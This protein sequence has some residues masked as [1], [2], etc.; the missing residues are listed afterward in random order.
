MTWQ[1]N[2]REFLQQASA[3][4]MLGLT[5]P[6]LSR[7]FEFSGAANEQINLGLIGCG[8]RGKDLLGSFE[9]I[10]DVKLIACCDPDES[11]MDQVAQS[12]PDVA[13][14]VDYRKLLEQKEIDAVVIASTNHWHAAQAIHSLQA[15]KDVYVEKPVTFN[16]DQGKALVAAAEKYDRIIQAGTQ[17]RSDSGLIPAFELIQGGELGAIKTIRGLC[18]RNRTGIGKRSQPLPIPPNLHY[19]LWLGGRQDQPIMRPKIHY[20]WHWDFNTGNGDVGNQAPHEFDLI[21]WLLQDKPFSGIV[22]SI[23]NRFAWDDAGDTPNMQTVWYQCGDIPV[24]FEVNNLWVAPDKRNSPSYRGAGVGVIVE[25]EQGTFIGGRGG[26]RIVAADDDQTVIQQFKGDSGGSHYRNFIEAVRSRDKS[27]L[28]API[29][30]SVASAAMPHLANIS[31]RSGSPLGRDELLEQVPAAV[32]E[33]VNRQESQMLAWGIDTNQVP[34]IL[35]AEVNFNADGQV[36]GNDQV[37]ELANPKYRSE[38]QFPH[39]V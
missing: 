27:S 38:F 26:G 7:K 36:S 8:G 24:I 31:Y 39:Q 9:R 22:Q 32:A 10:K 16:V 18:Y 33:V 1:R 15:G 3:A 25:C 6:R 23:G 13:R 12:R 37:V 11:R 29:A 14:F 19:D 35:G 28:R 21:A 5:I 17:N 20:D 4:S 34:Y 30:H 2:R